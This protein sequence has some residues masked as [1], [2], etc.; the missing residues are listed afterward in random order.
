ML[1]CTTLCCCASSSRGS[2]DGEDLYESVQLGH[3]LLYGLLQARVHLTP[4]ATDSK[5]QLQNG[6]PCI[7]DNL[8]CGTQLWQHIFIPPPFLRALFIKNPRKVGPT[9][10]VEQLRLCHAAGPPKMVSHRPYFIWV[11]PKLTLTSFGKCLT[12]LFLKVF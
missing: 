11:G 2:L 5:E 10:Q 12:T 9:T 1:G 8:G 3:G 4:S 6:Y 7:V